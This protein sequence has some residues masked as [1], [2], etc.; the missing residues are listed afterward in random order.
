MGIK[1]QVKSGTLTPQEAMSKV[2]KTSATYGWCR[3][4]INGNPVLAVNEGKVVKKNYRRK[5]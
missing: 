1:E 5:K 3:R 2:S 4:K